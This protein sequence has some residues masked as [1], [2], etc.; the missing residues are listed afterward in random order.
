MNNR[1]WIFCIVFGN[2][3]NIVL[4]WWYYDIGL[5]FGCFVYLLRLGLGYLIL[6]G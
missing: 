5:F 2:F 3:I 6:I 1:C 4:K